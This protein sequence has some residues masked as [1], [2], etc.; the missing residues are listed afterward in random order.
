M[1]HFVLPGL[2]LHFIFHFLLISIERVLWELQIPPSP[3]MVHELLVTL[4]IS[5]LG[6]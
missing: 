2:V 4:N 1:H 6:D 5:Y 3:I